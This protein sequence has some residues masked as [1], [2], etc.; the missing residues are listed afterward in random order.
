[1][2]EEEELAV[3]CAWGVSEEGPVGLNG[4]VDAIVARLFPTHRSG[5]SLLEVPDS[6]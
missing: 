3:D 2:E 6:E 4:D 1:V 5:R